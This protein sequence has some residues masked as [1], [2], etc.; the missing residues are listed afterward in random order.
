MRCCLKKFGCRHPGG[1]PAGE[2]TLEGVLVL[3]G[4][5]L[6]FFLGAGLDLV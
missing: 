1:D 4:R 5:G 3:A 2:E 6:I